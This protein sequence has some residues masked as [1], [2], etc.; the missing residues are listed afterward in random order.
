MILL[1]TF[2]FSVASAQIQVN[3]YGTSDSPNGHDYNCANGPTPKAFGMSFDLF[4]DS[5]ISAVKCVRLNTGEKADVY[6]PQNLSPSGVEHKYRLTKTGPKSFKSE[7]NLNLVENDEAISAQELKLFKDKIRKCL[8]NLMQNIPGPN[9]ET[10]SI[11]LSDNESVPA[12]TVKVSRTRDRESSAEYAL[13]SRCETLVHEVLHLHG[14]VDEYSES[15]L[16]VEF[17]EMGSLRVANDAKGPP[18][19]TCRHLGPNTSIMRNPKEALRTSTTWEQWSYTKCESPDSCANPEIDQLFRVAN[20]DDLPKLE[21]GFIRPESLK[22]IGEVARTKPSPLEPAH[23]LAITRPG[24]AAEN[25]AYY[26]CASNAY[27]S[28]LMMTAETVFPGAD[29]KFERNSCFPTPPKCKDPDAWLNPTPEEG[30]K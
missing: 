21:K 27:S 5:K 28:Q 22:K 7:I 13:N 11:E 29:L 23:F 16:H 30:R 1:L 2:L 18:A 10:L 24:C 17:Q 19:Y 6:F 26:A 3:P 12:S 20:S 25:K 8:Q 15:L 9:G 4:L 14:L